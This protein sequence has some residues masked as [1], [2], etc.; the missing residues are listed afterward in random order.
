MEILASRYSIVNSIGLAH[1]GRM[2]IGPRL[3]QLR[4]E[5]RL[6]QVEMA[7]SSGVPQGTISRI[8]S[9]S[10]KEIPPPDII[11][12]LATELNVGTLTLLDAAGFNVELGDDP[13]KND[14]QAGTIA[15]AVRNWTPAQRKL[16]MDYIDVISESLDLADP[17]PED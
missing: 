12:P 11:N 4:K 1:I 2:G 17:P 13:T 10:Y 16:L 8:E 15:R 7:E 9:G 5:A 6:T 14:Y 3:K